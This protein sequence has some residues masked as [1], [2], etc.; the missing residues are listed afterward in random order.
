MA[1]WLRRGLQINILA[2]KSVIFRIFYS[3]SHYGPPLGWIHH[4][5]TQTCV[6]SPMTRHIDILHVRQF[7][8]S[9]DG[10]ELDLRIKLLKARDFAAALRGRT[11]S[12]R[13]LEHAVD[14]HEAAGSAVFLIDAS[15]V[16]LDL[17]ARYCRHMVAAAMLAEQLEAGP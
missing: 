5:G 9:S 2:R 3:F 15:T 6:M 13:A 10:E 4:C 14:A 17:V 8:P 16:H 1:E 12:R 11:E 7:V